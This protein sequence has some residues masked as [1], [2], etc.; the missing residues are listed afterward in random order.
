MKPFISEYLPDGLLDLPARRL[1]EK[2]DGPK[3]FHLPGQ[4][5]QPLVVSVLQHGNEI[6]G[7]D[8]VRHLLGETYARRPLPRNLILMVGNVAAAAKNRRFLPGQPDFNRCWPDH[9]GPPGS[10]HRLFARMTAHIEMQQPLACIDIH[11]NTGNN[12]HYSALN[13]LEQG[14]LALAARFSPTALYF[15][16]PRGT[17]SR[18]LGEFCPAITLECGPPSLSA[19]A[20]HARTYLHGILEDGEKFLD[21][22]A[23]DP[24]S[25]FEM[26]TTV[27]ANPQ[28]SLG[29]GEA[30][31]DIVLRPDLEQFNFKSI[32]PGT[33]LGH[34]KPTVLQPFKV[35]A[36]H[37]DHNSNFFKIVD[38][39]IIVS[40][41]IRPVMLT[42]DARVVRQDCLCHLLQGI[43][44]IE[45]AKTQGPIQTGTRAQ[46]Q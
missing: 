20:D 16:H 24:L 32:P 34:T 15:T 23:G 29:F 28:Y 38:G 10:L 40:R 9:D 7:W 12:P 35:S 6:S 26:S 3:L 22:A 46:K 14:H 44:G 11:N 39:K 8:A 41:T 1:H 25:L 31:A 27:F 33:V 19:G 43:S 45:P 37:P 17:Q 4:V 42:T 18:A 13:H 2:L 5:K 30:E 21:P 36:H